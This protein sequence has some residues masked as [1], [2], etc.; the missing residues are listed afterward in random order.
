M[1][2]AQSSIEISIIIWTLR[3]LFQ[4]KEIKN[5]ALNVFR[6]KMLRL[7]NVVSNY[8]NHI[9]TLGKFIIGKYQKIDVNLIHA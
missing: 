1:I 3:R 4:R 5:N 6:N 8:K 2:L 7:G 9:Y